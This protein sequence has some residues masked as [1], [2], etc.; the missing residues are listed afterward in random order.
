MVFRFLSSL[1]HRR[2]FLYLVKMDEIKFGKNRA[3]CIVGTYKHVGM[4]QNTNERSAS[5]FSQ[6]PSTIRSERFNFTLIMHLK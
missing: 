1:C 5:C 4:S 2:Y 6:N 3:E